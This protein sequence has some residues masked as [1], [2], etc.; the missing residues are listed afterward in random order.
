VLLLFYHRI[1]TGPAAGVSSISD[2]VMVQA[3]AVPDEP[4][5]ELVV[6]IDI[7]NQPMAFAYSALWRTPV[8]VVNFRDRRVV[9]FWSAFANRATAFFTTRELRAADLDIVSSPDNALLVC[10][11]R[12][13]EF[14]NGLTGRTPAD[15]IPTSIREPVPILKTTWQKWKAL[16]P[17]TKLMTGAVAITAPDSP[18]LNLP[19]HDPQLKST[20]RICLIAATQPI[21]VPSEMITNRPLN[22]VSGQT[23]ILLVRIDGI[24]KAFSREL[25]GDLVPRFAPA[26]DVK[27]PAVFWT[28][29]DTN[30][31]WSAAGTF[32]DGDKQLKGVTLTPIHLEDDLYWNVMKFWYPNLHLATGEELAAALAA[33][34]QAIPDKPTG[35][36]R[37]P[38]SHG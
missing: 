36:R 14:I 16:H 2:P 7:D 10:N 34:P 24:A 30:S 29:L 18:Q 5:D 35:K 23:A 1:T 26:S 21:A 27:K 12:L 25:P 33:P 22:L 32:V 20:R 28:D 13:G 3:S 6:G 19:G 31:K 15:Q 9:L 8:V 4:P 17:D 37:K 38:V 11:S